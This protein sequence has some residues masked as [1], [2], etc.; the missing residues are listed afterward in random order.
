MQ[1]GGDDITREGPARRARR[2]IVPHLPAPGTLRPPLS[3]RQPPTRRRTRPGRR[4]AARTADAVL[5]RLGLTGVAEHPADALPTGLARMVE[6]G[7][8]LVLR[9]RVL[10]L[11]EPATS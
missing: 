10:L 9:P 11:D 5:D 3:A 4:H 1:A 6:V 8:A 2:G 7:R